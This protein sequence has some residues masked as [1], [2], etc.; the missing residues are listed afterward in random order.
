[1]PER[2]AFAVLKDMGMSEMEIIKGAAILLSQ[3]LCLE[4][5]SSTGSITIG[6][7]QRKGTKEKPRNY[8]IVV[9]EL[10][11]KEVEHYQK[12]TPQN[13]GKVV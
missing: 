3:K 6:N 5:N 9:T 8:R 12:K 11:D 10:S 2:T 4:T 13:T 7:L 1:M